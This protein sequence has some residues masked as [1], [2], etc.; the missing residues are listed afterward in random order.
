MTKVGR[1]GIVLALALIFLSATIAATGVR[2]PEIRRTAVFRTPPGG[3]VLRSPLALARDDVDGDLIV[4]SFESGQVIILNRSGAVLKAMGAEAG[5]ESPYGVALDSKGRIL[6]GELG[7][8]LIKIFSP[9]GSLLDRIDL[10][11][12]LGKPVAPGRISVGDD[13]RIYVVDLSN[14]DLLVVD[15]GGGSLKVLG[16]MDYPQKVGPA[17]GGRVIGISGLGDAVTVYDADG[18]VLKTFGRHGDD[19]DA[20]VSFPTGFAVDTTG[21]IWIADAFQHRL[22][23]FS[24]DGSFLFNYGSMETERGGFF[25]PVDLCFGPDGAL[26]VLEKGGD[27][28]QVFEVGDLRDSEEE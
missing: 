12:L 3:P 23:V 27:R 14:H 18:A 10:S 11:E 20:N 19:S 16:G 4:S 21:R 24:G 9:A 13:G 1:C 7:A 6:V 25:F 8:G 28:I 26:F 5:L 2:A 17:G 15:S 22:K